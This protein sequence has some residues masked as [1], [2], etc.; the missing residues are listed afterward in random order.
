MSFFFPIARTSNVFRTLFY[1]SCW[2]CYAQIVFT[3][4]L[5]AD[6]LSVP[7]LFLEPI[8]VRVYVNYTFYLFCAASSP[9]TI[10]VAEL[11]FT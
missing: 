9:R 4:S 6:R 2:G 11:F 3:D 8:G 5:G 10:S 7:V 1:F